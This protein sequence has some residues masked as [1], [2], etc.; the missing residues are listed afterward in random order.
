[1]ESK[2]SDQQPNLQEVLLQLTEE[3]REQIQRATGQFVAEL[4]IRTVEERATPFRSAIL[5]D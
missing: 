1:M 2:P 5:H 4:K 3:Q